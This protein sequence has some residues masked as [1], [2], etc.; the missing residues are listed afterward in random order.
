[1]LAQLHLLQAEID[2]RAGSVAGSFDGAWPCRKGCGSCCTRLAAIP[3][4]TRP[5]WEQ[6]QAGLS[7]MPAEARR[8]IEARIQGLSD[9]PV[10]CPLFDPE[11]RSCL[12]YESRPIA[13]RTYGFFVERDKGLYCGD[14]LA[15]VESG[16]ARAVVWGNAAGVEE[17]LDR[18]GARRDLKTWLGA[19][20]G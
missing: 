11:S 5:E 7:A 4:L 15:M 2:R 1:M 3:V 17:Q 8:Q 6:L 20:T 18:L 9:A 19:S 14:I 13:C 10:V 16:N 12:V